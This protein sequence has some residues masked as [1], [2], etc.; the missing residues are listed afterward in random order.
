RFDLK[1]E[2]LIC[3]GTSATLGGDKSIDGLLGYASDIFSSPFGRDSVIGEQRQNDSEFLDNLAY[4]G[5]NR[6]I[7]PDDLS[8][9]LN[10]GLQAY[11][12]KAYELYFSKPPT[13]SLDSEDG[14]IQLGKE[15]KQHGQ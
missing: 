4:L 13:V 5:L 11:L 15:L 9:A 3:A 1:P 10:E 2:Q 12:V 14:R 6:T 8:Q 7:G